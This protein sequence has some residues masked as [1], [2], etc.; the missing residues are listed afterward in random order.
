MFTI[1]AKQ[2]IIQILWERNWEQS[3]AP[4]QQCQNRRIWQH[5]Q[6][7]NRAEKRGQRLRWWLK[8]IRHNGTWVELPTSPS[9]SI[10]FPRITMRRGLSSLSLPLSANSCYS[11]S[12]LLPTLGLPGMN[13]EIP[14]QQYSL[15]L[16][17][18]LKMRQ[19]HSWRRN[20]CVRKYTQFRIFDCDSRALCN[21]DAMHMG[22]N[23][24]LS[25]I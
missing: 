1:Q 2:Q 17:R 6:C 8:L 20:E 14:T 4:F 22:L 9:T 16:R 7:P 11:A 12:C 23:V 3:I 10:L 19:R 18:T 25:Q 15:I 13:Y 21:P 5:S 24:K